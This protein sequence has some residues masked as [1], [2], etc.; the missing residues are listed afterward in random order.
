MEVE[1]T[2]SP[3]IKINHLL[4]YFQIKEVI[5]YLKTNGQVIWVDIYEFESHILSFIAVNW[6]RH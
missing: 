2:F 1:T 3:F 5:N 4:W 6:D